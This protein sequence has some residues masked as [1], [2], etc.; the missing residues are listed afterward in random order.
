MVASLDV[1]RLAFSFISVLNSFL[2]YAY[3]YEIYKIAITVCWEGR[4]HLLLLFRRTRL[5]TTSSLVS[6]QL[7]LETRL[8]YSSIPIFAVIG[9]RTFPLDSVL[10]SS[11]PASTN[12]FFSSNGLGRFPQTLSTPPTTSSVPLSHQVGSSSK[13]LERAKL[14]PRFVELL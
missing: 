6:R 3:Y 7:L 8:V 1:E 14:S 4:F 12:S 13:P 10:A 11:C 5:P 2:R 9:I